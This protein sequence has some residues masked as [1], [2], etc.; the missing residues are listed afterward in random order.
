MK[1]LFT[2]LFILTSV[3]VKSQVLGTFTPENLK[4]GVMGVYKDVYGRTDMGRLM[5]PK[6]SGSEWKVAGGY[7]VYE[8]QD[9]SLYTGLNYTRYLDVLDKNPIL[10]LPSERISLEVVLRKDFKQLATFLI[11]DLRSLQGTVGIGWRIR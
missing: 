5:Y 3:V 6:I 7:K 11:I 2:A 8:D 4:L 10:S 9:F 1:K